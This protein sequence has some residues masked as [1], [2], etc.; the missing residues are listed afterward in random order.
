MHRYILYRYMHQVHVQTFY[1]D[2]CTKY[3]YRDILYRYMH[4]ACSP[5][6]LAV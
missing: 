4:Q 5:K 1:T 3:M 2:T 6:S